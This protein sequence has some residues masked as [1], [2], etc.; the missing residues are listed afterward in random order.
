MYSS[1]GEICLQG[2][3]ALPDD[4]LPHGT[5]KQLFKHQAEAQLEE[6]SLQPAACSSAE[7]WTGERPPGPAASWHWRQRHQPRPPFRSGSRGENAQ[8]Q[9]G[10]G[11]TGRGG[12]DTSTSPRPRATLTTQKPGDS[13]GMASFRRQG[14]EVDSWKQAEQG[15]TD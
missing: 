7:G 12:G 8:A 15:A 9:R 4:A 6:L 5:G 11:K 13:H 10:R 3:E 2:L 14:G 1:P